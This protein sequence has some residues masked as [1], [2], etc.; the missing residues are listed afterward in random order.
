MRACQLLS[1]KSL[2]WHRYSCSGYM[3]GA[4][5]VHTEPFHRLSH[6]PLSCGELSEIG[7]VVWRYGV[8]GIKNPHF[9]SFSWTQMRGD[10]CGQSFQISSRKAVLAPLAAMIL[11]RLD[12]EHTHTHTQP[13][14]TGAFTWFTWLDCRVMW[15]WHLH[16]P[17]LAESWIWQ[18]E[19]SQER[20]LLIHRTTQESTIHLSSASN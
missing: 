4:C 16:F 7:Q 13:I 19:A 11:I 3:T 9:S 6:H 8:L 12:G 17:R 10:R 15:P 5:K 18:D 2:D 20:L 14:Y 1:Q